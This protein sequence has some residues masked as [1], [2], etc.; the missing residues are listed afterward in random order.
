MVTLASPAPARLPNT[1]KV[2]T[3]LA[4]SPCVSSKSFDQ[5]AGVLGVPAAVVESVD[6]TT[7]RRTS[8]ACGAPA[9]VGTA[10]V[11]LVVPVP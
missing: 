1:V 5:P 7:I 11:Q 10:A 3:P 6:S 9:P 8:S 4:P 2:V